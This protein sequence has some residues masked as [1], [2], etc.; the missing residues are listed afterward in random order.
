MDNAK[1]FQFP[2][3]EPTGSHRARS[4][5]VTTPTGNN[6]SIIKWLLLGFLIIAMLFMG[7]VTVLMIGFLNTGPIGLIIGMIVA[8]LP[9]PLYLALVIWIDRFEPEPW[10]LLALT[11]GWGATGAVFF[12]FILNTIG[13][14]IVG[15]IFGPAAGQVFGA[16]ISAPIVEESF[17]A[18]ALFGIFFFRRREFD[19]V[20]D[21]IVYSAMVGLGFAMTENFSYYGRFGPFL[22]LLRGTFLAF[23]HPLFT[24]MTGIGLGLAAES[25]NI[26]VKIAAPLFGLIMAMGL[27]SFNNSVG[28]ILVA[29]LGDVGG[30]LGLG[31]LIISIPFFCLCVVALAMIALYRESKKIRLYLQGDISTGRLTEEEVNTISSVFKRIGASFRALTGGGI[32]GWHA[33]GRFHHVATELAFFRSNIA[34]GLIL[35]D[36][37]AVAQENEYAKALT[38]LRGQ[39][40]AG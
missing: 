5:V 22:F 12:S 13:G 30:L 27:H 1:T 37:N 21:G 15:S 2:P 34:K 35:Q 24:S 31:V 19:G 7:L 8:I 25:K 4:V 16:S 26:L 33:R 23:A 40:P 20:M 6:P 32:K 38:E 29:M 11:F 18:V 17:K 10:W 9:V 39:L 3:V 14:G 36:A 28:T